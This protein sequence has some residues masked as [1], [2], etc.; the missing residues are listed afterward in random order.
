MLPGREVVAL[1]TKCLTPGTNFTTK[2][3]ERE[4]SITASLPMPL[5]LTEEEAEEL[6]RLMH[7]ALEVVLYPY[8][9]R[10]IN[11]V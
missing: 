4:V 6:D 2:L 3:S 7:N 9:K 5:S 11:K 8:F 10:R 1:A